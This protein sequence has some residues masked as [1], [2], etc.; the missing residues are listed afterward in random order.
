MRKS[1]LTAL[2]VFGT[3][4]AAGVISPPSHAGNWSN[5][6]SYQ[7]IT[8]NGIWENGLRTNGLRTNAAGFQGISRNGAGGQG[9]SP[10]G[11]TESLNGE[12]V[13]IELPVV[14]EAAK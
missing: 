8:R 3:I 14:T 1:T 9:T 7:G 5:G 2:T 12:V 13:A 4:M 10:N 6:S 11:L